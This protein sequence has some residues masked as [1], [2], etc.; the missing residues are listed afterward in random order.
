MPSC[1]WIFTGFAMLMLVMA[2]FLVIPAFVLV[3]L[4]AVPFACFDVID[5]QGWNYWRSRDALIAGW[6]RR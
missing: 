4:A 1:E 3:H 5:G 2:M 6:P